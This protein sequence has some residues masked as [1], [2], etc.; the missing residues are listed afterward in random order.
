V[1]NESAPETPRP[2]ITAQHLGAV[3]P[4]ALLVAL[5]GR[6]P[7]RPTDPVTVDARGLHVVVPPEAVADLLSGLAPDREIS[8]SF[9]EGSITIAAPGL[10]VIRI[11]IPEDG[12]RIY[13][14]DDGLRIGG[15]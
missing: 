3:I 13:A 8:V 7:A 15:G 10:P 5:L 6:Q 11:A 9:G 14:G 1:T 4:T 2:E 12:L